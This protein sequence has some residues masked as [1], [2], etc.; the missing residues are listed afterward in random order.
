MVWQDYFFLISATWWRNY[1]SIT[2]YMISLFTVYSICFQCPR[3]FLI[4]FCCEGNRFCVSSQAAVSLQA[5]ATTDLHI[6]WKPQLS[7]KERNNTMRFLIKFLRRQYI[8]S[9][10]RRLKDS[11]KSLLKPSHPFIQL[12]NIS[13]LSDSYTNMRRKCSSSFRIFFLLIP[14]ALLSLHTSFQNNFQALLI[15]TY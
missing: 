9:I 10:A 6:F 13:E 11:Q 3:T 2:L 4:Q 1:P 5:S 7:L 15:Q 8:F 12:K 14:L